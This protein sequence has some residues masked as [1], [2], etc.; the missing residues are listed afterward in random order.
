MQAKIYT[1]EQKIY[2]DIEPHMLYD[3]VNFANRLRLLQATDQ[4]HKN[5]TIL[6]DGKRYFLVL[7]TELY[8][9]SLEDL[10]VML[11][12]FR[13]RFN[14]D[15]SCKYQE[16]FSVDKTPITFTQINYDIGEASIKK[17]LDWFSDKDSFIKGLQVTAIEDMEINLLIPKL[18]PSSFYDN[19]YKNL[20]DWSKDQEK[21]FRIY[22][23]I[24]HGPV[25]V[26]SAQIF[27]SSNKNAPAVVYSNPT[28]DLADHPLI[29]HSLHFTEDEFTLLRD[30]VLKIS[31]CIRD[32][33]SIYVCKNYP[34]F[35][36]EKG[37]SSPLLFF[38][39]RRPDEKQKS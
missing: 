6:Q 32:L 15:K 20:I 26:G 34:E 13:R 2:W 12:A 38:K 21:R 36:K 33:I 8:Q 23:K 37:F 5:F 14:K 35:L 19:L 10:G 22:N 4:R 31:E 39:L 7:F 25:V 18:I 9:K 27:N 16:K 3:Y 1:D 30:G 29:V 11:L 24:K 28:A 17:T